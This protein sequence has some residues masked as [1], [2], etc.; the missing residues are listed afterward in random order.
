MDS[1]KVKFFLGEVSRNFTRNTG[2]QMTAIGTVAI[3]IVLL[4]MFLFVRAALADAG[5]QLL[6]QIEI[7]AYLR[8]DATPKQVA[9][10]GRY[11]AADPRIASA[12]FVPKR[13]GLAELR[14][15]TKGTIDTALLT[16]NPLPDKFRVKARKPEDVPAV[17]AGV[18]RLT[19]VDNVVYGQ[20]IVQRLL[21]LGAVLRRVGIGVIAVF[22]AVAGI[23]IANTIRLTVFARRREIAI[24]QLVGAT[25]T[26]IRLPFICEGLIAGLF[27]ALVAVGLLAIARATLW[28][29]LLEALPWA[30]LRAV[31]VDPRLLAG[32]LIL[33]GAAIGIVAS[34]I[35]VGRHLRT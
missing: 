3:T 21:Q 29:R 7:S 26:Y 27:G 6:D 35:A 30:A 28:P 23:I 1:G 31:P 20:T 4:G 32:E 17:A 2:M 22:F 25:N 8:T 18:R 5:K 11:L 13:Q 34:W 10:I 9:A 16:E 24:M 15:R 12:Q 33:V 19:G 14:E